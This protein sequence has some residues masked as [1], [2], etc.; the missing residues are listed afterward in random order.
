MR[1]KTFPTKDKLILSSTCPLCACEPLSDLGTPVNH[2]R[3]PLRYDRC[4]RCNLIFMNPRPTQEWYNH[5]YQA[6]FWKIKE[7]KKDNNRH[8]GKHK[9]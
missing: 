2:K 4:D 6:E 7:E 3:T 9:A 8:N 5:L 1:H